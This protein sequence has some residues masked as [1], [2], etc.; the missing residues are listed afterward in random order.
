MKNIN[1]RKN[2]GN[3]ARI[4]T[5]IR[6]FASNSLR[7][8]GLI[9]VRKLNFY[10][11]NQIKDNSSNF[12]IIKNNKSIKKEK[13]E[14]MKI[15]RVYYE[16][17]II[18]K[19]F[20]NFL[21]KLSFPIINPSKIFKNFWDVIML[22]FMT[23]ILFTIP[24]NLSFEINLIDIY[25]PYLKLPIEF[26][27]FFNILINLNTA[28]FETIDHCFQRKKIIKNYFK[29]GTFI[30]DLI[31]ILPFF[32]KIPKTIHLFFFLELITFKKII[33]KIE[34]YLFSDNS[35]HNFINLGLLLFNIILLSHCF[36]CIW[37]IIGTLN[38]ENSWIIEENLENFQWQLKYLKA[39]YFVIITMS[40]VGYGD[41]NP[42]NNNEILFCSIFVFIACWIFAYSLSS[43]GQFIEEIYKK[44]K[45]FYKE[46]SIINSFMKRKHISLELSIRIQKYLENLFFKQQAFKLREEELILNKLPP[47]LKEELEFQSYGFL[48]K[49][50][51]FFVK[52]FSKE[53]L[54]KVSSIIEEKVFSPGELIFYEKGEN[55]TANIYFVEKG[56]VEYF[57][58]HDKNIHIVREFKKGDYFGENNFVT[59][60]ESNICYRSQD[61]T[62]I[63]LIPRCDFVSLLRDFPEDYE[64]FCEIKDRVNITKDIEKLQIECFAC[65]EKNH[66]LIDCPLIH[67]VPNYLTIIERSKRKRIKNI[68][69]NVRKNFERRNNKMN[70]FIIKKD[71]N[72][73][74][75]FNLVELNDKKSEVESLYHKYESIDCGKINSLSKFENI[76][77]IIAKVLNNKNYFPNEVIKVQPNENYFESIKS[78]SNYFPHNNV[79]EILHLINKTRT[80]LNKRY[81]RKKTRKIKSFSAFMKSKILFPEDNSRKS[82]FIKKCNDQLNKIKLKEKKNLNQN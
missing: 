59:G 21:N 51:D 10:I 11:Y 1:K 54:I 41:I 67:Y 55:N 31:A 25:L 13:N 49:K 39:F 18:F 36:A 64:K 78:F 82:N 6:K 24:V 71:I 63:L 19:Y 38:K 56:E 27:F 34:I 66:L 16:I 12:N 3:L 32:E 77:N 14:K 44:E 35:L 5:L 48:I 2:F 40:T 15:N 43:I 68:E 45:E 50:L 60:Y 65:N 57:I 76:E 29:S 58:Q 53:F 42:Q 17:E 81:L 52:N 8:T 28:Y 4:F 74:S 22:I 62:T 80:E 37:Y 33:K 7:F 73:I 70:T 9:N 23:F 72:F 79:E 20:L 75:F 46:L 30:L 47:Q 69:M 26:C 61:Y